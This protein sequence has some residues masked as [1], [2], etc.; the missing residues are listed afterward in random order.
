M[1]IQLLHDK[2][3]IHDILIQDAENQIFCMGDLDDF[4]WSK[5]SWYVLQ[6]EHMQMRTIALLYHSPGTPT[7]LLFGEKDMAT[8]RTLLSELRPYLPMK[9]FAHLSPGLVD[10]FG[11]E[12]VIE[13]Y[14]FSH[15]MIL[16]K[17][18]TAPSDAPIR[19][20]GMDDVDRIK[21]L[22]EVAYPLHWFDPN[23]VKTGKYF[24]YFEHERL[25]G[26]AGV[27]VYSPQYKVA[28]LGNITTHPDF[29]G[30]KI[31]TKLTAA[32]CCDLKKTADMI[33]LNVRAN[34]SAA[35]GCYHSLGFEQTGDYDEYLLRNIC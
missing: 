13:N 17:E 27:H 1:A 23:M 6:N 26:V 9:M 35:I 14:G 12:N 32:L 22:L 5:T 4:L 24:G 19:K 20:L 2:A 21:Q 7:L 30:R 18:I 33:G 31:A 28:A 11:V 29:R 10:V 25:V 34:N 16:R 15:K 8:A 3:V